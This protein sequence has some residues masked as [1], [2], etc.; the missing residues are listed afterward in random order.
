[1]G[2]RVLNE[3]RLLKG[4]AFED[5]KAVADALK[6][7]GFDVYEDRVYYLVEPL[8]LFTINVSP[9]LLRGVS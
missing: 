9:M 7:R 6:R 1:V 2:G 5:S 8:Q 4:V 3:Y